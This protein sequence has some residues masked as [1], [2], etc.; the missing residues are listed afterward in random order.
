M[1]YMFTHNHIKGGINVLREY[2]RAPAQDR[3]GELIERNT[4]RKSD[5]VY[6]N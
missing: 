5:S 1:N 4:R 6:A 3:Y 2:C